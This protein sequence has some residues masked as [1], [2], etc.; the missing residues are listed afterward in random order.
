MA[1]KLGLRTY[2]GLFAAAI[3][4]AWTFLLTDILNSMFAGWASLIG[5]DVTY[6]SFGV[7]SIIILFLI[8][9]GVKVER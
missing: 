9:V 3:T 8:I 6:F 7:L 4:I 2:L 5:I 1:I